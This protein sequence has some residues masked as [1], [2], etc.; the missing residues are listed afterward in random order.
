MAKTKSGGS[1]QPDQQRGATGSDPTT[2]LVHGNCG[3]PVSD[4]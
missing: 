2:A 1:R 4:G 3:P